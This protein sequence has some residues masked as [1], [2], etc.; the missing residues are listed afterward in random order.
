MA[1]S[2]YSVIQKAEEGVAKEKDQKDSANPYFSIL[3][4]V[5]LPSLIILSMVGLLI[6]L[7][8]RNRVTIN[9]GLPELQPSDISITTRTTRSNMSSFFETGGSGVYYVHFNPS[10]LSTLA[11]ATGKIIP[12]FSSAATGLAAFFAAD[13]IRKMSLKEQNDKLLTPKQMS[14][15]LGLLFNGWKGLWD[16]IRYRVKSGSKFNG[17][18]MGVVATITFTTILG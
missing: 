4:A 6:G 16:S 5:A 11:S 8:F 1:K 10:S 14:L 18:L 12:Y 17:P 13:Y 2:K 7:T 9:P 3:L 15:L